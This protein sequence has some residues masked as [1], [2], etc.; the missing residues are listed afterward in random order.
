MRAASLNHPCANKADEFG[1]TSVNLPFAD[2]SKITAY[3]VLTEENFPKVVLE[4]VNLILQSGARGAG[5]AGGP[6]VVVGEG[7]EGEEGEEEDEDE[8]EVAPPPSKKMCGKRPVASEPLASE[9]V[10]SKAEAKGDDV[11]QWSTN[12]SKAATVAM[13]DLEAA[14]ASG[15]LTV[16]DVNKFTRDMSKADGWWVSNPNPNPNPDPNPPPNPDPNPIPI[17]NPSPI[18]NPNSEPNLTLTRCVHRRRTG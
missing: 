8:Q 12:G 9:P 16:G 4:R 10:N 3:T 5:G 18:P 13:K 15:K 6:I 17:P 2:I 14:M 7:E 1:A 11:R